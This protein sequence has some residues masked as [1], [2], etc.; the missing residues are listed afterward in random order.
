MYIFLRNI[1]CLKTKEV[2]CLQ[3]ESGMFL[4][5]PQCIELKNL[6]YCSDFEKNIQPNIQ[7]WGSFKSQLSP[8][9]MLNM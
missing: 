8:P 6:V 1:F 7:L 9:D 4:T 3:N 5:T 2:E